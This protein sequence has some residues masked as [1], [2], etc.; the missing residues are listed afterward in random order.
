MYELFMEV[1]NDYF[2]RKWHHWRSLTSRT[3]YVENTALQLK[4]YM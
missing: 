2:S 4:I 1:V 3:E